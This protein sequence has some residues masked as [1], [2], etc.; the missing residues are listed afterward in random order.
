MES[1]G[2][3]L[4]NAQKQ[5]RDD[6]IDPALLKHLGMDPPQ[7]RKFV[8]E[9]TSRYELARRQA[10][11][12]DKQRLEGAIEMVG[13]DELQRSGK[14]QL[15]DVTDSEKLKAEQDRQLRETRGRQVS[16]KYRKKLDA[17]FRAVSEGENE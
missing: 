1:I 4:K 14:A 5:I 7:F 8:K 15:G 2:R 13:S 3:A 11:Q 12:R 17:Y 16:P 10:E 9:Y 6:K